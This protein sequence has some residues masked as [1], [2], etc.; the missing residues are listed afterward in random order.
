VSGWLGSRDWLEDILLDLGLFAV[1]EVV[2]LF[3]ELRLL[4]KSI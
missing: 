2:R 4:L 1:V 3:V